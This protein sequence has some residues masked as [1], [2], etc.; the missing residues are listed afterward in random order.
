ML[1]TKHQHAQNQTTV[2]KRHSPLLQHGVAR[3]VPGGKRIFV[4]KINAQHNDLSKAIKTKF[5]ITR[6]FVLILG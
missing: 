1:F 3:D 4:M 2:S 6:R 5:K